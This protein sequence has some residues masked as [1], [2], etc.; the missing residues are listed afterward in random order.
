MPAEL[1]DFTDIEKYVAAYVAA[2]TTIVRA[3]DVEKSCFHC[4][5]K[6]LKTMQVCFECIGN[7]NLGT[8]IGIEQSGFLTCS[9]WTKITK[10]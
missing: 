9:E 2:N 5:N 3:D 10:S 4:A 6:T 1:I 8:Y 7:A